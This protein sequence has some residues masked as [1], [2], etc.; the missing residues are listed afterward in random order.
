[1]SATPSTSPPRTPGERIAQASPEAANTPTSDESSIIEDLSF[2]YIFDDAGNIVRLSKGSSKSN[3]SSPPTPQEVLKPDPP[4]PKSPSPDLLSPVGRVSL[5]RSESAFP[6]LLGAGAG[7]SSTTAAAQNDKPARSFQRVASGP[8]ISSTSSYLAPTVSSL[9][10]PRV[11]ARRITMEDARERHDS[12]GASRAARQT[13]DSNINAYTLQEEKENINE[14]DDHP[15]LLSTAAATS[16]LQPRNSP[17]LVTRSVSSTAARVTA[18]RAYLVNGSSSTSAI[19]RPLEVAVPQRE[20]V[21]PVPHPRQIMPGPNR[22]GR[23]MKSTSASKYSLSNYDRISEVESSDN[24]HGGGRQSPMGI[25]TADDETEPEDEPP[26][27]VDAANVPL[28]SSIPSGS[29]RTRTQANSGLSTNPVSGPAA[30]LQVSATRPRRSASLSDALSELI[31]CD[32]F[33]YSFTTLCQIMTTI[34][35]KFNNSISTMVLD[36]V[37]ALVCLLSFIAFFP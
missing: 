23:I 19:S 10:K 15:Y 14:A 21:P 32:S 1:M 28:P 8:A 37:P 3:H 36:L 26:S 20:R 5:S 33:S 22:A 11:A 29:L 35:C 12:I 30:L 34:I 4:G 2:D 25:P 18:A 6:V 27:A 13:L 9:S 31:N 17:P 24:E 16:K 7:T